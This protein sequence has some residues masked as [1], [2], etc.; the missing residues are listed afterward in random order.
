MGFMKPGEHPSVSQ[1]RLPA[2]G[3]AAFPD[4]PPQRGGCKLSLLEAFLR[5]PGVYLAARLLCSRRF[6]VDGDSMEPG[7]ADGQRLLVDRLVYRFLPPAR[8]DVV[9]LRDPA[10]PGVHCVKHIVGLPGEH[11]Q[12]EMGCVFVGGRPLDEPYAMGQEIAATPFPRQWL[13]D[14]DEY[15]V[16]GDRRQGSRDSR[17]FGPL[18]LRDIVG[19]E[20]IRYRLPGSRRRR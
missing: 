8:G 9:V 11:V 17:A 10:Q 5:V 7:L 20:W 2:S 16:L 19:K 13:L 15:F 4:A 6:V 12:M 3:P 1:E 18:G 14:R